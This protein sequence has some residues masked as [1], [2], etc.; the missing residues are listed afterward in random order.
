MI[1]VTRESTLPKEMTLSH[2]RHIA[3]VT[4]MRMGQTGDSSIVFTNNA[5]I[6]NLNREY[7]KI[8]SPTDV[9][10]FPSDE[11]DPMT[12]CRYL[13]DIIISTER[14]ISQSEQVGRSYMDELAMLIVHGCLHLSGL[15]HSTEGDKTIMQKNQEAILQSLGV[16]NSNWPEDE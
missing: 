6:Q 8:D 13:G 16:K 12:N 15:D 7:R 1:H 3:E 10:S 4:F 2:I 9:L 11:I 5:S 14:A